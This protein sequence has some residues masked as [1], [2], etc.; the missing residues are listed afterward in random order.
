MPFVDYYNLITLKTIAICICGTRVLPAKYIMKTD[1]D[2]FVRVDAVL[3]A[4]NETKVTNGLLYG[5]I[6]FDS[7]PHRSE[8]S[9]WYISPEEWPHEFYPPWA[10]GPGYI[11]SK[12]IAKFVAR[13][14]Q[15]KQLKLFKLEDVA[16]GIWIEEFKK[17]G[18]DI[19]YINDD[20]FVNIGCERDYILAHYQGPRTMLCLWQRLKQGSD[21]ICC[22]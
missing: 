16:M 10:H 2:A 6:S 13:G 21:P 18:Q 8:E 17:S 22:E 12:D 19:H 14:H 11:V 5:R 7:E 20:R 1:D 4:L 9:K 15:K 3:S